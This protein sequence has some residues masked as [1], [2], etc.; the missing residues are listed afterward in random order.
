MVTAERLPGASA[1]GTSDGTGRGDHAGRDAVAT[2]TA[3]EALAP[4]GL[5]AE[6]PAPRLTKLELQGF[7]SFAT[8]TTF[9]FEPGITAVIGPNGSGKSNVA[10]AIR[11]V[12]GE[13]SQSALR[14]KKTEDVIFA[15]GTG[16]APAGMAEVAVTFDNRTGW[17]QTPFTEVTVSRRAFRSGE[18]QYLINGRRVRLKDVHQLTASLGQSHT[19]VGQ[20][21]VD[22]ALSL[23]AED[24]RSLFE[25]AADLSGLR[26]KAAEAERSLAEADA[27]VTR[28]ED[29][30]TE[31]AP[32]LRTLER[33]ARQ[34]REWQGLHDRLLDLQRGHYRTLLRGA[35][36]RLAEAEAEDA[37]AAARAEADQAETERAVAAEAAARDAV[38]AARADLAR[39]DVHVRETA[40]EARQAGH[41][42]DLATERHA[43]LTRRRA[44]M[45]DARSGLDEQ[46]EAVGREVADV[47]GGLAT[48]SAEVEASRADVARHGEDVA[49]LGAARAD[50]ERER[51]RLGRDLRDAE[52]AAADLSRRRALLD[53]RAET[54]AAE[55]DRAAAT[56]AQRSERIAA[57]EAELAAAERVAADDVGAMVALDADLAKVGAEIARRA[58]T[59]TAARE[60]AE[61]AQRRFDQATSRLEVLRKMRESGTGLYAG[62]RATLAAG[63]A[64]RLAGIR[65][66]LAAL[67]EVPA[68]YET[69]VEV[70]LGGHVQDVVVETWAD[71]EA[72]IALLKRENA[73]RVTFQPIDTVRGG[74]SAPP[75]ADLLRAPGVV[76]VA[77]DLVTAAPDLATIVGGLLGRVLVVEDLAAAR[78]S[79]PRLPGGWS[80][81]T[82][83]GEIARSGGSVTG[84]SAARE[85]GTLVRERDL[86]ELPGTIATLGRER[87]AA[88]EAVARAR[89]ARREHEAERDR[90]TT[91]RAAWPATRAARSEERTTL[92]REED[93]LARQ[94]AT[95]RERHA[96]A[97]AGS[98]DDG[99]ALVAAE[100]DLGEARQ[101]LAALD[102]RLRAERR[103]ETALRAQAAALED[104]VNHRSGRLADV[105]G[106]L[107]AVST[108]LDRLADEVGR[109]EAAR[110]A[111]AEGREPLEARFR[112]AQRD[113]ERA[114][115]GAEEARS[116]ALASGQAR[117]AMALLSERARGDVATVEQRIRDDLDLD[118]ATAVLD[119]ATAVPD[120]VAAGDVFGETA[121]VPDADSPMGL[122]RGA[123]RRAGVPAIGD[124]TS[125][126]GGDEATG[127]AGPVAGEPD[128]SPEAL[129]ATE[130]EIAR[131][132]ER[133]RRVGY[134]GE[135]AVA[136]FER[137]SAHHAFLQTQIADVHGAAASL[138]G[139]LAEL[140]ATMRDRF[141]ETFDRVAAV[142]AETFTTLFGG[143]TAQLVMAEGT[144][145]GEGGG[146]DIVARPPGK[147]L[148]NLAL[149]SG[150]ERALTAA[151]LLIA[152]LRVNPTPFCLLDEVD[153]ALDEANV[154]RFR[155]QLGRLARE[156][157]VIVITHNRGTIEIADTLYGVSMG[158]DGV[159]R[160]L[161]LR[162]SDTPPDEAS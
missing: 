161:S 46:V 3:A 12:L 17:L 149:L 104:E 98:S 79:L 95:L 101:G 72:A 59:E 74:R 92:G 25:H 44:D 141:A 86:R 18:S 4:T 93:V 36:G 85:S 136:E 140:R 84:G 151:A 29:L 43:A 11:W 124:A 135:D 24:R 77:A 145:E 26:I 7:K 116:I 131:L 75:P 89:D 148:Q 158:G 42:R 157:Q 8:R 70:A 152:I 115:R 106:E 143:G 69:A 137:E 87:D 50:R 91:A 76:G 103:R 58:T 15:G 28:L 120:D 34:A 32:R 100:R 154:V 23:R 90:L 14:G 97:S 96:S 109:V 19:V 119:D 81:V 108:Q 57:L 2:T 10:D 48:L 45:V 153:A 132:R 64:G 63:A 117:G 22:A 159:S 1:E 83:R 113:T 88:A 62:V 80:A 107:R 60:G 47:A 67:V 156:T 121:R 111:A 16:R 138:R 21:L 102:E 160:L 128:P 52:R 20:G 68:A 35:L 144:D 53:Q 33:S 133:L 114:A 105:E 134:V 125:V 71:A 51:D 146:I 27:N 6:A 73:G 142:F 130:R 78:A 139:L 13:T 155:E 37:A 126:G 122:A 30:L 66:V 54:D 9:S 61:V 94:T 56:L 123:G 5:A 150:G 147:R 38:E 49:R 82:P 55:E 127:F 99:E 110:R 112:H 162:L 40:D 118:D 31:L 129:A 39:H 65:G 41:R